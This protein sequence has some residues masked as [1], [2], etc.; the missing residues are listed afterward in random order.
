MNWF[1][2]CVVGLC[3]SAMLLIGYA[4]HTVNQE[5]VPSNQL[6][7]SMEAFRKAL[8]SL[9]QTITDQLKIPQ[10]H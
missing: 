7:A 9:G 1:V 5:P 3:L 4:I 6:H 10:H 2:F 8:N